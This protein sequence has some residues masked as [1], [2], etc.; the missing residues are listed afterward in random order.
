MKTMNKWMLGVL[1][2]GALASC[3]MKDE[4]AGTGTSEA[5][6]AL[7]LGLSVKE[8]GTGRAN[9]DVTTFPVEITCEDT[10]A[11]SKTFASYAEI[12][13]LDNVVPLAAG[14]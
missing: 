3:E 6:G 1:L 4:L 9:N 11:N 14:T 8:P 12:V 2:T 7:Q 5:M 13:E 10:P